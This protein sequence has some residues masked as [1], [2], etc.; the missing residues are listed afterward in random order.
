[1]TMNAD[2]EDKGTSLRALAAA[3][4]LVVVQPTAP[5]FPS[6]WDQATHAPLVFAFVKDA[7]SA[8]DTDPAR[9]HAMGFSQGGG[10]TWRMVCSHADFFASAAPLG[11]LE[12]CEFS[13]GNMPT[14][15]VSVLM[16][17]GHKDNIVS[18]AGV[19][20][21]QR[22]KALAAWPFG[23]GVV[24][25]SDGEHTATR[26]TTP[27]GTT[28]EFWEHDY[29]A[30]SALLGGHCF[31]GGTDVGWSPTQFGCDAKNAFVFGELAVKFFEAHPMK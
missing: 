11:G 9:A 12:G 31:P 22:D 28:F 30:G 18:F 2:S 15:E 5:G 6:S 10:M 13:G 1:M 14:R 26:Y 25:E 23:E 17:H 3:H 7:A 27:S 20:V 24:I 8:Y 4:S 21:P 19:A 29:K 16:G